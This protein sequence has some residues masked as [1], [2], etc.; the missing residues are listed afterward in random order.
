MT[1]TNPS[2]SLKSFEKNYEQLETLVNRL[3]VDEI[4]LDEALKLYEN[5]M[6]LAKTCQDTLDYAKERATGIA[7][8]YTNTN[9][10]EEET[11]LW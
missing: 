3:D 1:K 8:T 9:T 10:T 4:S 6:K 7:D 11:K 5:A 2:P